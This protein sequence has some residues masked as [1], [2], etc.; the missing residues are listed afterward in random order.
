ME[1]KYNIVGIGNAIVDT[2]CVV[3]DSLLTKYNLTKGGMFLIDEANATNLETLKYEEIK[4]G[5]S[6]SNSIATM[7]MLGSKTALIGKIGQDRF[8]DI[9][10]EDLKKIGCDFSCKNKTKTGS[11]ATSYVL[12]TPDGERTMCTY[13]GQASKINDEVDDK[14][15]QNSEILY[16]EGYLWDEPETILALRRAISIA[17]K[18]K[19]KIAFSLSDAFCVDRHREEF[20]NIFNHLDFLFANESEIEFLIGKD[21]SKNNYQKVKDEIAARNPNLVVAMTRS[22]KGAI[23]F[24]QGNV[25]IVPTIECKKVVDATG[26]GDSFAAGFLHGINNDFSTEDSALLGN[27]LAGGVI[28]QIGARLPKEKLLKLIK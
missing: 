7:A 16:L 12:V 21:F 4:S 20:L 19:T 18:S 22:S 3:E 27:I 14:I 24:N 23:V 8:G 17:T 9:F 25:Q 15:I 1:K 6:V 28:S 5:G 10:E 13:L 26:A 2:I 11:T